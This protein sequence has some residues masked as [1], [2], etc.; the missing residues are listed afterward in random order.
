MCYNVLVHFFVRC[1][2]FSPSVGCKH[3]GGGGEHCHIWAKQVCAAVK[4]MVL[5]QGIIFQETDQMVEDFIQTRDTATLGQGGFG[6]FTLVQGSKIQ[7][8][9][10]WY[11]LRVPGSQRHIPTQKFLKYP[12]PRAS[13]SHFLTA[14]IKFSCYSYDDI[15]LLCFLSLALALSLLSTSMQRLK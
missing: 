7:L 3:P 2:S 12:P 5:E 4:G 13:I 14:A 9:Q 6:E 10:L 8:N 1:Q 15:G 11:R